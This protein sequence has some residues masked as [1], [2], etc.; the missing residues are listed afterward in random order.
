MDL[1]ACKSVYQA[2]QWQLCTAMQA[3]NVS[4]K[5]HRGGLQSFSLNVWSSS[6]PSGHEPAEL[7]AQ[8]WQVKRRET[9]GR[10][11]EGLK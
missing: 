2:N 9:A 8:C 7:H 4:G 3:A 11:Q 5:Q 10:G 1:D 6:I